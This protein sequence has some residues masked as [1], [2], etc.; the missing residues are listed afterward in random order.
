MNFFKLMAVA[1]LAIFAF[2]SAQAKDLS[3]QDMIEIQQLYAK[4]N[5]AIDSGNAE[6]W[7]NTFT[8]DGVFNT[9]FAGREQLMGFIKMWH[10]R[11]GG[12]TR[13]HWNSNLVVTGTTDGAD[14]SVY[15]MLWDIGAKPQTI[16]STGMYEDKL[17]KTKNGWRFK[18][19]VVKGDTPPAAPAAK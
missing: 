8:E 1:A 10:E 2:A 6:A 17:V 5:H 15:L 14:G 4:Y 16:V 12:A 9:R 3:T 13:R 7:A 19:R 18:S 11:M